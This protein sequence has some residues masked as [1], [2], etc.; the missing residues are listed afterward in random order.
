MHARVRVCCF[1]TQF[2]DLIEKSNYKLAFLMKTAQKTEHLVV[3][4]LKQ[5]SS[6][7]P[8][9]GVKTPHRQIHLERP[10]VVSCV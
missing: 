3:K 1:V 5:M 6:A 10:P 8:S 2:R 9:L 7:E 4:Q